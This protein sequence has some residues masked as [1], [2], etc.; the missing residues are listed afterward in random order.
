[1][2]YRCNDA[3]VFY[4]NIVHSKYQHHICITVSDMCEMIPFNFTL[5]ASDPSFVA[6]F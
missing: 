1:M 2:E 4:I 6:F 5:H 3:I